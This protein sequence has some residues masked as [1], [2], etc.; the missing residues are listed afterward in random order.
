[1][2]YTLEQLQ[3]KKKPIYSLRAPLN[4]A[5]RESGL[6]TKQLY[7]TEFMRDR[8]RI[9]YSKAF[10]RLAGKTQVYL[11]GVDD[12]RRTRLTHTLEVSQI[13]RSIAGPLRL[14]T[15]LVEAIA[16]G[17]D[18]GHTPFGHVGERMLHEI[19]TPE[20][21]H[22]LGKE[23]PLNVKKDEH[24]SKE[25]L[26]YLGFKHNL[27]SL[28]TAMALEKNYGDHG[29]DLTNFTL[30]GIQAHS[31]AKYAEGRLPNHDQLFYYEDYLR[32]GC[33][34]TKETPAW[35]LESFVV[36]EADEIAQRHHDVEDAIRGGLISKEEIVKII[37]TNFK[38]YLRPGDKK[39]LK[40]A[41]ALDTEAFIAIISR[42][43]V[44]MFV[45]NLLRAS[46]VNINSFI[47]N[48]KL[49]QNSFADYI[50][51]HQPDDPRI[52]NLIAYDTTEKTS[53]F[54]EC[55]KDFKA[56][57]TS[58]VL[59]SYDIQSADAKGKYVIRK[60]F[61]AYYHSPQQLPNHC[62]LEFLIAY[63]PTVYS[64]KIL[65]QTA[66][67]EGIGKIRDNFSSIIKK[68]RTDQ[69]KELLI[70]MRVICDYIAGMTD[71]YAQKA[72]EDLY[73]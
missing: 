29:L 18:L 53:N 1:M 27:Q 32:K 40:D 11:S 35:S 64:Q 2:E 47:Y 31:R 6:K 10:R 37:K 72:Y 22:I 3:R 48:E 65:L 73:G 43:I 70:L 69:K 20:E 17:H 55:A 63:D 19:M 12:H 33:C 34:L 15:D 41:I 51:T 44:N 21:E 56:T 30:Y 38:D 5:T 7:R 26:P 9:L 4:L 61:Q 50:K 66:K 24:L 25:L 57:I 58:R 16:L 8:D 39:Q 13:A 62:V 36:A 60:L 71:T 14:D 46:V 59:S 67:V 45:T 52:V 68:L 28:K 49:T 54:V 23:C 42:I